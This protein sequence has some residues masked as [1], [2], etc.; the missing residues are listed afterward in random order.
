MNSVALNRPEPG[1]FHRVERK[2]QA[3]DVVEIEFPLLPRISR[4]FHDSATVEYG[5]IVFSYGIGEDWVKLRNRGM[6][7][8]WQVYPTTPW[9]YAI[10]A[11]PE[12]IKVV[13]CS[14]VAVGAGPFT[15]KG[16]PL[17]LEVK[18]RHIPVWL[19]E[20]NVADP[21]PPNPVNSTEPEEIVSMIP[22]AAAKL[23]ITA[24]PVLAS[25]DA[26]VGERHAK[27]TESA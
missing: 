6:T 21:V 27:E 23:R 17:K 15:R 11:V 13:P 26:T 22:Y 10:S 19:S 16:S 2:W 8:D 1:S 20:D 25:E 18:A 4:G 24:F 9:D 7:A 12:R 5:A 3:G 14:P